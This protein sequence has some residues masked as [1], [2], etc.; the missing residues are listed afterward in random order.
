MIG[1]L[2]QA[3]DF[4]RL[5]SVPSR[6]RSAHFA[7]HHVQG[8]PVARQRQLATRERKELSTDESQLCPE[9]VDDPAVNPGG[10]GLLGGW[11]G[12]VVPK[13]HARRSVTRNVLKRQIRAAVA[14]HAAR[15]GPG[16]WLVRLRSPFAVN[17]FPSADSA[18]LREAAR[19]ELDHLLGQHRTAG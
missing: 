7:L 17:Q 14:R 3:A 18:A 6:Q 4:Q 8:G 2:V 10:E 1:R 15:L 12:C 13:R 9:P 5:L 19:R 11:W 16:L